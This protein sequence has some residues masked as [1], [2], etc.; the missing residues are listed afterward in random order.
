MKSELNFQKALLL[1]DRGEIEKGRQE[2]ENVISQAT[3]EN[4]TVTMIRSLVC[5]GELLAELGLFLEAATTINKALT[6]KDDTDVLAYEFNRAIDL[7]SVI[8]N[9]S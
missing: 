7:L 6:F 8:G 4:D 3:T 2:L 1:L 5:L 9:R